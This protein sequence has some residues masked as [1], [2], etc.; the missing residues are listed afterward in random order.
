MCATTPPLPKPSLL[1]RPTSE[2]TAQ[3]CTQSSRTN[4]GSSGRVKLTR[5]GCCFSKQLLSNSVNCKLAVLH[6]HKSTPSKGAFD[7]C[8]FA[9]VAEQQQRPPAR[10]KP[11]RIPPPPPLL[12]FFTC[13]VITVMCSLCSEENPAVRSDSACKAK[14][15]ASAQRPTP[16]VRTGVDECVRGGG[17]W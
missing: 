2:I 12:L 13:C 4:S 3:P 16:V 9:T 5:K 11:N 6:R 14:S 8:A 10:I 1:Q 7:G 17:K 15:D